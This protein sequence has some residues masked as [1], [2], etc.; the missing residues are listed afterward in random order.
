MKG[1]GP[2]GRKHTGDLFKGQGRV[3][4]TVPFLI[5]KVEREKIIR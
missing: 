2:K 5:R 1:A 4:G 3:T